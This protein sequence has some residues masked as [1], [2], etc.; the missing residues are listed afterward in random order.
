MAISYNIIRHSFRVKN[1]LTMNEYAVADTIRFYCS[2]RKYSLDGWCNV[3]RDIISDDLGFSKKGVIKIID[4]LV[5]K[6]FLEK[7]V[8][9]KIRHTEKWDEAYENLGEQS[10][11]DV[12]PL[13]NKVHQDGEQSTPEIELTPYSIR[14]KEIYTVFASKKEVFESLYKL[15]G[16]PKEKAPALKKFLTI[17]PENYQQIFDAA[18][19]YVRET[20]DVQFRKYIS[21]WLNKEC[22]K[23]YDGPTG[24][25]SQPKEEHKRKVE[26]LPNNEW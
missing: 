20:P 19:S 15:Y 6:G 24:L 7:S 11:P 3:T 9:G 25:F 16:K 17:K 23:D 22:W 5:E 1:N 18:S 4:G 26:P 10:T 14:I 12:N 21:T 13:V 8:T 2:S